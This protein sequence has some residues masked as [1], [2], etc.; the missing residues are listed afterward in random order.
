MG[1]I[2]CLSYG[3]VRICAPRSGK[4]GFV[5]LIGAVA[6]V[7]AAVC[8]WGS[9][10]AQQDIEIGILACNLSPAVDAEGGSAATP[11][12]ARVILCAFRLKNGI[13]ETYT[14]KA[15]IVNLP[16]EEKRTLLWLVRAPSATPA[17]PGILQQSYSGDPK[18]PAGQTPDM[19]GETNSGI[20][21]HSMADTK[22]G[23]ARL[24]DQ[25]PTL[26]IIVLEV[27]LKLKS[28]AG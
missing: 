20:V 5:R 1:G 4:R 2:V 12:Q 17:P 11:A 9:A 28:T 10:T 14:G 13:E 6:V 8:G 7:V 18:T 27:E 16:A 3:L 15:Q 24:D 22:E 26:G 25:S 23:S 19:I 21:L